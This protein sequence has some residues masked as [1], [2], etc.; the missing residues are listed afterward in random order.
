MQLLPVFIYIIIPVLSSLLGP[1]DRETS[2]FISYNP[3]TF[4]ELHS[5]WFV[6]AIYKCSKEVPTQKKWYIFVP[7]IEVAKD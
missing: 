1:E 5:D 2:S 4:H 3:E 7:W 6:H